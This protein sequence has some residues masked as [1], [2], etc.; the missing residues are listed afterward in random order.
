[1]AE[2]DGRDPR[3]VDVDEKARS[4]AENENADVLDV[5]REVGD[6]DGLHGNGALVGE[7]VDDGEV[8]HGEVP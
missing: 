4:I 6:A 2:F 8:M 1:M 3:T 5:L 7:G